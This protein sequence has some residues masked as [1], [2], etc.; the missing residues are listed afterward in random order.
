MSSFPGA[1]LL[2]VD[3]QT[4]FLPVIPQADRLLARLRLAVSAASG[5]G[6]PIVF[7]EQAPAKLGPTHPDLL[8][9][10]PHSTLF[11]K[12]AFSA[13]AD[14]ALAAHLRQL[15]TEHLILAGLETPV[16]LYQTALG[17]LAADL[18][19]TLL[20]DASGARR[21]DDART[22][23]DALARAGVHLLPT[24]TI[25]YALLQDTDHPFFKSYTRL[26]KTFA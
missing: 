26:V 4:K 16:C 10:A 12:N 21:P 3:V 18:Q 24:E 5:L 25:F 23:L 7:T 14:P 2:V 11:A 22:C 15:D 13:F 20:T 8:A 1:T 6:L 9:A 19:V 17:A